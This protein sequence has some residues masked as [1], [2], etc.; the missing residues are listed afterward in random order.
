MTIIG[1]IE[2]AL[3]PLIDIPHAAVLPANVIPILLTLGGNIVHKALAQLSGGPLTPVPFSFGWLCGVNILLLA[4][5]GDTK[6]MP[7]W[8]E[9]PCMVV[10]VKNGYARKNTSWILGRIMHDYAAWKNP[11]VGAKLNSM[12]A[13]RHRNLQRDSKDSQVS[14]PSQTGLCISVYIPSKSKVA[15]VASHDWSFWSGLAV[16]L[17][18]ILIASLPYFTSSDPASGDQSTLVITLI[19]TV[20]ALLNGGLGQWEAEKWACRK[21]SPSSYLLTEGNGSQH[22]ILILGNGHGLDLEDLAN[23]GRIRQPPRNN[24]WTRISLATLAFSWIVVLFLVALTQNTWSLL[25]ILCLG[26]V[27]NLFAGNLGRTPAHWVCI[28]ISWTWLVR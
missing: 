1:T 25:T 12:L 18:Q 6:L 3:Q 28:L 2:L 14:R 26:T 8:S 19:A 13:E 11:A 16:I 17:L 4:A 24:I 21:K 9:I 27:Q 20:L 23:A 5:V 10:N 15:G 22:A 7:P